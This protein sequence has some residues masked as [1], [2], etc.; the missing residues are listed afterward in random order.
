MRSARPNSHADGRTARNILLFS[1]VMSDTDGENQETIWNIYY[2]FY[3]DESSLQALIDQVKILLSLS[4]SLDAWHG[5]P[6]GQVLRFC[7]LSTF[8]RVR[9]LWRSYCIQDSNDERRATFN[10]LLEAN[11]Q[12]AKEVKAHY[13][14]SENAYVT[15][16][17]RSAAPMGTAYAQNAHVSYQN[18]WKYGSTSLDPEVLAKT[19]TPNPLFTFHI[20]GAPTLHYGTDPLLGFHL[21]TAFAPVKETLS[22]SGASTRKTPLS[23]VEAAQL[24]FQEWCHV[25]R[26]STQTSL[27]IRFFAGDAIAFVHAL[28]HLQ[29]SGNNLSGHIYRDVHHLSPIELDKKEYNS[30]HGAPLTFNVIDTSNLVDHVGALNLLSATSPLLRS[31]MSSTLYTESLVKREK[32]HRAYIESLLC[33]DFATMSLLLDLFPIEYWTNASSSSTADDVML[34]IAFRLTGS[35]GREQMRVKLTWKRPGSLP[36]PNRGTIERRIRFNETDLAHILHAVY[37]NMFQHENILSMFNDLDLLKLKRS[38]TLHYHRGSF[39]AFIRLLKNRVAVDWVDLMNR[40]LGLIENNSTIVMGRNYIQELYLY[41]HTLNLYSAPVFTRTAHV[42]DQAAGGISGW[43][44][45]PE[46]VYITLQVPRE[47]L[48]ALTGPKPTETGTPFSHCIVQSSS[49]STCRPWQNVFSGIQITFGTIST[50]GKIHSKDYAI[51]VAEDD[52]RWQGK[53]PL[54]VSFRTPSWFLL[55]EPQTAIV[56]FGLQSTMQTFQKFVRLFGVGMNIFETTLGNEECVYVSRHAPNLAETAFAPCSSS[57]EPKSTISAPKEFATTFSASLVPSEGRIANI[58]GHMDFF[59]ERLKHLLKSGCAIKATQTAPCDL[60]ITFAGETAPI[61]LTFPIP[62]CGNKSKTRIARKSASID[63]EAP[64]H[65]NVWTSFATF[66]SSYIWGETNSIHHID[67]RTLPVLDQNRHS[68]LGW[69]S[70]HVASMFS[71]Q[72]RSLREQS[73]STTSI[74]RP[75]ARVGFKDSLFSLFMHF[76]GLQG[77]KSHVFGLENPTGGGV[78]FLIFVSCMRLDLGSQTVILDTG[79]LPITKSIVPRIRRFLS[80]IT[81]RGFCSIKVDDKELKLWR[82]T[83]P[84]F[85][86]RCRAWHHHSTCKHV[87]RFDRRTADD[88]NDVFC[89]CGRGIL[90]EDFILDVPNWADVARLV[91]RTA[92]SPIFSVPIVDPPFEGLLTSES[93]QRGCTACGKAEALGGGKLMKCSACHITK[94]CSSSCQK[95]DWKSHKRLCKK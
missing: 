1:L 82:Q 19:N 45:L 71:G 4:T 61:L 76:P 7:D 33:G 43:K 27:T 49:M 69:L 58:S 48:S 60:A 57:I 66:S 94:Y 63:I 88:V 93:V 53:S 6:Y 24:Q 56:A 23:V 28:Y 54:V 2:H 84:S 51:Q 36:D 86:E 8:T 46:T 67:L 91:T 10:R 41:L 44:D 47:R 75:D 85:A 62:V 32:D 72:E 12:R 34:D 5:T 65:R 14:G 70:P 73:V 35:S 64:L 29:L 92:I 9:A 31:N 11:I 30:T 20:V 52:L 37:Q 68:S 25:F 87:T 89:A 16:G 3:L 83:L 38:S 21:A 90:P 78:H 74:S 55:L 17:I 40:I 77:R 95:S 42:E 81:E 26:S 79:V 59:S 15:T 22:A 13:V 39:V 18:Y 50:T 80:A